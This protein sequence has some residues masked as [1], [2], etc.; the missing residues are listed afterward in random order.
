MSDDPRLAPSSDDRRLFSRFWQA[1]S[2]FWRGPRAARAW[3]LTGALLAIVLLQLLSQYWLNLWNRDFF[4]AI[5]RRDGLELFKQ[6][7]LFV[8]LAA[9]SVALAVAAVWGRMTMQRRWRAWLSESV[10]RN[11]MTDERWKR[12]QFAHEEHDNP[13]YRIAEDVRIATDAPVDLAVG[14]LT[15]LLTALTFIHVLWTVGG[16]FEFQLA[17]AHVTLPGYLVIGAVLYSVAVT[18]GIVLIGRDLTAVIESKNRTEAQLRAAAGHLRETGEGLA[19]PAEF[20]LEQRGIHEALRQV[21]AAWRALCT[22]LM[23]TTIVSHSHFVLAPVV[24]LA[25][26]APKYLAGDMSLGEVT[27]A[28]AAFVLVSGAF[29][30]ISDNY[31]RLADWMSSA[32]RVAHLLLSLDEIERG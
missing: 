4:D 19:V 31:Q 15:S 24:G 8:P 12:L 2:G 22:Q 3:G 21:I 25:L 26:A 30:W 1:A 17:G 13:E 23:R 28:G 20:A 9:M 32:H 7:L 6:T 10:L 27:Q 14:L 16:A 18:G 11:W 29:N 5:G